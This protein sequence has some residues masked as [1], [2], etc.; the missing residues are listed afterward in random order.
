MQNNSFLKQTKQHILLKFSFKQKK[1]FLREK[2][3][4]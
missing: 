3:K 2:K 1:S 4:R